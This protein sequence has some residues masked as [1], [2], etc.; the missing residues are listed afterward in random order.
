M[1]HKQ[2]RRPAAGHAMCLVAGTLIAGLGATAPASAA[3]WKVGNIDFNMKS[4]LS[5]GTGMRLSNP[6]AS[7]IAVA[8]GGTDTTP[9]AENFD[10]GNL[11]FKRGD[12]TTA[13]VRMLHEIDASWENYGAFVSVGYFYDFINNSESSTRRTDLSR[14]TR[15]L[16]GRRIDL[17]DAYIYGDFDVNG[18]PLTVRLGNQMINWGEALYRPGGISQTNA[19]DVGKLVTPGTNI[20]EAYLPSPMIYANLGLTSSLSVEAYYQFMWRE[21]RLIP[22]GTFHSTEDILGDGAEGFFYLGDPGSTGLTAAQMITFGLG[23]PRLANDE[24]RNSGQYGAALR[25][26]IEDIATE[27]SAYYLR[28]HSKSPSFGIEA[29]GFLIPFPPFVAAAPV[30]YYSYFPEDIDLYGTSLSFPLGPFAIGA[31]AAYQ[32][33]FPVLIDD[34]LTPATID[35]LTSLSTVRN[36]GF[37]RADRWNFDANAS[38][39][40]G[41]SLAYIGQLPSMIGADYIEVYSEVSAVHFTGDK[42]AGT[43][44]DM[45][46]WGLTFVTSATYSNVLTSGLT[47]KPNV[48]LNWGVNGTAIDRDTA[49]TSVENTR[50]LSVGVSADY[51]SKYSGSINYVNNMGG[52]TVTRNSDRDYVTLTASY[53]F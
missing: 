49:G 10:D 11:N 53:S 48:N 3:E 17:Y 42:P 39:T 24:P 12:L 46:S 45:S 6:K 44:K 25:Y 9:A 40:I 31:E 20:R 28:Y 4:T 36:N 51:R 13:S 52:G 43:T 32:P 7:N 5:A 26:Y 16:A 41:P 22:V 38:L 27:I 2:K 19:V 35:A 47:L 34:P 18:S 29:T 50:A 1:T 8:N 30:G 15:S 14:A 37:T 21:T 23:I 33:D